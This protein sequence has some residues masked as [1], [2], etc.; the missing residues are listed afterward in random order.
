VSLWGLSALI[1][2]VILVAINLLVAN[3]RRRAAGLGEEPYL[4]QHDMRH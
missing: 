3:V 1:V 2:L 4:D